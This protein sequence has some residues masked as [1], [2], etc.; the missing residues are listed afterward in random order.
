MGMIKTKEY[1]EKKYPDIF[2]NQKTCIKCGRT[3]PR[4]YDFFYKDHSRKDGLYPYCIECSRPKLKESALKH[5]QKVLSVSGRKP[6]KIMD[7]E[8]QV[9][10]QNNG[11]RQWQVA[12]AIGMSEWNISAKFSRGTMTSDERAKILNFIK[13]IISERE[14][15]V[16]DDDCDDGFF[17]TLDDYDDLLAD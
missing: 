7:D 5:K 10:M 2:G 16:A 11:I 8:L 17:D 13:R 14:E 6:R 9:L 3:F 15:I 4:T 1:I 12:E